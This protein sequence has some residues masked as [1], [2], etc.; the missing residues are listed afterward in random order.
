[1]LVKFYDK[2]VSI[3]LIIIVIFENNIINLRR[4]Y[5]CMLLVT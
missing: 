4:H 5:W 1:M 3:T 2:K